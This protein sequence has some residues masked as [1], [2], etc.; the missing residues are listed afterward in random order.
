MSHEA[1]LVFM[2]DSAEIGWPGRVR[3]MDRCARGDLVSREGIAQGIK[4]TVR[5]RACA[6]ACG[7]FFF[8]FLRVNGWTSYSVALQTPLCSSTCSQGFGLSCL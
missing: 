3:A 5:A 8:S 2:L 4:L 7:F 6:L 1:W